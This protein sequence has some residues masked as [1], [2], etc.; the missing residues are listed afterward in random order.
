MAHRLPLFWNQMLEAGP[1][2]MERPSRVPELIAQLEKPLQ[3][4]SLLGRL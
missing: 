4:Y 3:M 2:G 1:S